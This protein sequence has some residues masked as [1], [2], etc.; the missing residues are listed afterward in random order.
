MSGKRLLL[1]AVGLGAGVFVVLRLRTDTSAIPEPPPPPAVE[2]FELALQA[3]AEGHYLPSYRFAVGRYRF[4]GVSLRPEALVTFAQPASG[5][6]QPVACLEATISAA[7]LRLRCDYPRVG[8]V[9]IDGR[10]LTRRVTNRLDT[11][12]VSAVVTVR[13]ASGE[14]LYSA[15]DS[16]VWDPG[17]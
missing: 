5:V 9:T 7:T 15:R 3:D 10:F 12:V 4:T 11:P 14:T 17:P 2:R 6:E 16:F 1:V 13:T 8:L